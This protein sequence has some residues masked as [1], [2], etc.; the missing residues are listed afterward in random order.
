M[1]EKKETNRSSL[2]VIEGLKLTLTT[3]FCVQLMTISYQS[4]ARCRGTKRM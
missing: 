1:N 4:E 3:Q 2:K